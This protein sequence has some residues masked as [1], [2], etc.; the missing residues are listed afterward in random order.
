MLDQVGRQ[1]PQVE[2]SQNGHVRFAERWM[3]TS[4][5][6]GIIIGFRADRATRGGDQTGNWEMSEKVGRK[7]GVERLTD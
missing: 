4:G 7:L 1:A 6:T 2:I 5:S 3:T